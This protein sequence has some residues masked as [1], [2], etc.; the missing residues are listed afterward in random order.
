MRVSPMTMAASA[1]GTLFVLGF[2]GYYAKEAYNYD[3]PPVVPE[4]DMPPAKADL[5]QDGLDRA[6]YRRKKAE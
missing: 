4:A 3:G 6:A 1:L 2:I 5:G